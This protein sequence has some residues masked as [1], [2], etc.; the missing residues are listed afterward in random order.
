[1]SE[2][3]DQTGFQ[4]Q[5]AVLRKNIEEVFIGD[6]RVVMHLLVGLLA[7]GHVLVEDVPGVGKTILA[8]ALARSVDCGFRRIQFTP[9][10]LPADI[11]GVSLYDPTRGEFVFRPGPIFTHV[12]LADEINR[13]PPRTQSALLEAM[14]E[15]QVSVDGETRRLEPPFMVLATM[16][17]LEHHGTFELPE[18]QL[19][20]FVLRL[21]VGY[22]DHEGERRIFRAQQREHPLDDLEAVVTREEVLRFQECVRDCEVDPSIEDYVLAIVAGTREH[23]EVTLGA[24]PRAT[25]DMFRVAQARAFLDGRAYVIP[26]DIK[27]MAL[28]VLP[29]RIVMRG[30]DSYEVRTEILREIM[31][32]IPVPA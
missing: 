13:T 3:I 24:S 8:R 28:V 15:R 30:A 22:P 32:R 31:D 11:L 25:L 6:Q 29:H 5:V 14:N 17:P 19:D 4:E 2:A 1:V 20:R 21:S 26:D 12:L 10:L 9:D 16:N 7:G 23:P 27:E 18:S